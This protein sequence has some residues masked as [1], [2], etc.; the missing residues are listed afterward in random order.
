MD[1]R[2]DRKV[3]SLGKEV[4]VGSRQEEEWKKDSAGLVKAS[5]TVSALIS[6]LSLS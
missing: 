4:G 3:E 5:D 2:V 1:L 6:Q